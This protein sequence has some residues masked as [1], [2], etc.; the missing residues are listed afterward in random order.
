ML[1]P[2]LIISTTS[3][4]SHPFTSLYLSPRT[5]SPHLF[6]LQYIELS[7]NSRMHSLLV[8]L[9]L[10][11]SCWDIFTVHMSLYEI[12][13]FQ[14]YIPTSSP[15]T[16]LNISTSYCITLIYCIYLLMCLLSTPS[17]YSLNLKHTHTKMEHSLVLS[18][19]SLSKK[20]KGNHCTDKE[21]MLKRKD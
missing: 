15:V 21:I 9:T 19:K 10:L 13:L 12:G 16:S 6:L 20:R 3:W 14:L 5:F 1:S 17:F 18:S 11:F 4:A 8:V 7:E 2:Y